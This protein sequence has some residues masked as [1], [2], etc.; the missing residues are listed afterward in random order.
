[1]ALETILVAVVVVAGKI[2]LAS[3]GQVD[4]RLADVTA[5]RWDI[6]AIQLQISES[7]TGE[8]CEEQKV[9]DVEHDGR[10]VKEY[11]M[12]CVY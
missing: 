8:W 1:L 7:D 10:L 4:N 9:L 5:W 12:D 11:G 6:V 2:D 3:P